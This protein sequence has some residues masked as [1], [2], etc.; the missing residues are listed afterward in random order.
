MPN[1]RIFRGL[2]VWNVGLLRVSRMKLVQPGSDR[3]SPLIFSAAM[4]VCGYFILPLSWMLALALF[5]VAGS[6][7]VFWGCV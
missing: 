3:L 6:T 1:C 4:V 2:H 7:L 5:A